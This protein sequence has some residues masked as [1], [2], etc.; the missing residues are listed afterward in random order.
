MRLTHRALVALGMAGLAIL[1]G[2]CRSELGESGAGEVKAGSTAAQARLTARPAPPAED[3]I[4]TA[5]PGLRPLRLGGSRDGFLFVPAGY[6]REQPAPLVVMLHG[7]GG[8]AR[9]GLAPFQALAD[10]AG[11][12]L[13]A[14]DSRQPSW[15][16]IR[17]GYGPDVAFLDRA[18]AWTF[19]RFA[20]DPRRIAAEGFSDGASYALSIALTNGDLFTHVIAFSPGFMAPAKQEGRP[21]IY[22]SHGTG[23]RVLPID[24]CSRRLV[25]RLL[26]G[27]YDVLYREFDGP[28]TVPP[29]IAREAL[30]WFTAGG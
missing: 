10:A 17:G 20:V 3:R 23:D 15:D 25:P 1:G 4:P 13:L 22:I 24:S 26:S 7:A 27:G 16:V 14:P 6:R 21:R 29:E 2:G 9:G 5:P 30:G 11:I 19:A 8:N 18:L 12:L 28:H